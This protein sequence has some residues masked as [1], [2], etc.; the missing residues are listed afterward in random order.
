[1]LSHYDI[2]TGKGVIYVITQTYNTHAYA[3]TYTQV[4]IYKISHSGVR[5]LW[6]KRN[7]YRLTYCFVCSLVNKIRA[8]TQLSPSEVNE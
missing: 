4:R 6:D 7:S 5:Y 1:M 3:H 8:Q 2:D